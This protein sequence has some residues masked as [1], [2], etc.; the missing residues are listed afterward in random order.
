VAT[1]RVVGELGGACIVVGSA[2]VDMDAGAEAVEPTREGGL[3]ILPGGTPAKVT[4][5]PSSPSRFDSPTLTFTSA[6]ISGDCN[7][8]YQ[9]DAVQRSPNSGSRHVFVPG[10]A[11]TPP[12]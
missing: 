9:A 12:T 1:G 5:P 6:K 7:A 11:L 4:N 10:E 8:V 2:S 3:G